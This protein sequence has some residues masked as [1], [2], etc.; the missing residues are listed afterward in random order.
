MSETSDAMD[1][2]QG[3]TEMYK[4]GYLDGYCHKV[5]LRKEAKR[6]VWVRIAEDCRKAFEKRFKK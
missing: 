4:Q 6:K 5:K 2:A 3:Y 1:T